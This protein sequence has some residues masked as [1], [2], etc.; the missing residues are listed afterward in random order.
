MP[1]KGLIPCA[2]CARELRVLEAFFENLLSSGNGCVQ[3][4]SSPMLRKEILSPS[5]GTK[6]KTSEPY[7]TT[8]LA[9]S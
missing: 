1:D 5:S 6:N 8:A 7:I 4:S 2:E 3:S 9:F